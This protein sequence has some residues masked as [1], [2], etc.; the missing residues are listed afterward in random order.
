MLQ[1]RKI[2]LHDK[3]Y[4]IIFAIII[5]LSFI[6]LNIKN[7][8]FYNE[9]TKEVIGVV[10]KISTNKIYLDAKEKLI[11]NDYSKSKIKINLGD[12]I[13]VIGTL[14][15]PENNKN[16]ELFD[17]KKYLERNNIKYIVNA[18]TI[19]KL[20]NNKSI[21]YY[22]KQKILNHLGNN[23]YLNTFLVG[24]KS[25]INKESI[26]S[27]QEN[28]I[29]HLFAISGMHIT[30][31]SMIITKI[32]RK[33]L[34]EEKAFRYTSIM[35][36]LYLFLVGLSPSILRGVLFFILFG[37]NKIY[38]FYVKPIN[39][40]LII[41]S[42][43]LMINPNYI[44][45]VGFQYSYLI[46]FSLICLS[47]KLKSTNYFISLFKVSV[48]SFVTSIPITLYNFY[49]INILS[50]IY[51]LFFVPLV[52][53]LIFPLSLIT[54]I[55]K[56]IE[57]LFNFF[58]NFMEKISIL[59]SQINI[60]K[61]TFIKLPIFIYILYFLLIILFVTLKKKYYLYVLIILILLHF[62]IP[63]INSKNYI[64]FIDVE[65]GDSTLLH[66]N[67]KNTL[68]DTGGNRNKDIFYNVIKPMM[69][70]KGISKIDNLIITHGDYDHMGEAINL[71]NN[72]K[73][74]KVIFNCGEFNDLEKEL[75]KVLNK[76][77]IPYYSCISELNIENNKLYFLNTKE[78][79]N[80]NDNSNVIYTELNGHK[81]IFMGD[82]GI[83]REKDI[84]AKYNISDVDV[85][86]VGHHG[87]RTSSSKEFI[88][89]V[90]PKY[91]IISVGKNNRYGHPNK[92]ILNNLE[93]SKIYRT[94]WDGSI[95]VKFKNKKLETETCSS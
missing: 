32:L 83:E 64:Y 13:E 5:L 70:S 77:K 69:K 90:N 24:D 65:Q 34:S 42:F 93:Q 63:H 20:N 88:N 95:I 80:E 17:Y 29:S 33:F 22:I 92:E 74:E 85:L 75:I 82:A 51:N 9:N 87:S 40:F 50:I 14:K 71:V 19:K 67:R 78:Y 81:F 59:L 48:V 79:D 6:R 39:L 30:L 31:L 10:T 45:D 25:L 21:Y 35:L 37:L 61:V 66:I 68:I 62:L 52:S 36:L 54:F 44:F 16:K 3:L 72:F 15:K 18:K 12:K 7:K 49:Q 73:V 1:L 46:S 4:I 23:S 94:D 28:G 47:D 57:P 76:K 55:I 27:Y 86:K 43:S 41:I 84:L 60:G 56:P 91:A 53:L 38:Y 58:V 89:E 26:R 2:L 8:S 11:I